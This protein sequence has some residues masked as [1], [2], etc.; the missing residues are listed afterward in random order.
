M[1]FKTL[2]ALSTC[3]VSL[4]ALFDCLFGVLY[5]VGRAIPCALHIDSGIIALVGDEKHPW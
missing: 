1:C 4:V 3:G 2:R 5:V